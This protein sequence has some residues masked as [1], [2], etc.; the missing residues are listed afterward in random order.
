MVL[1]EQPVPMLNSPFCEE[2]FLL[3]SLDL[4]WSNLRPFTSHPVTLLPIA[5]FHVAVQR[6]KVTPRVL[7]SRL[8][9]SRPLSRSSQDSWSVA[10]FWTHS[11]PSMSFLKWVAQNWTQHSW[12]CLTSTKY[13]GAIT[14]LFLLATLLVIEA[15]MP[16]DFLATWAC[17]GSCSAAV[18][19]KPR[20]LF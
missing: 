1:Q 3:S 10:L 15:R 8:N 11:S 17:T 7:F 2:N 14:A 9:Y 6:N 19:Q 4:P 18:K 12:C 5:S 20:V 16:L 13:R